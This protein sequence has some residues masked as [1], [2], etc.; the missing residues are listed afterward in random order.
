MSNPSA[1]H[2]TKLLIGCCAAGIVLLHFFLTALALVIEAVSLVAPSHSS[3]V[4]SDNSDE[5]SKPADRAAFEEVFV[6][7]LRGC[8]GGDGERE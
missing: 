3:L 2:L 8:G 7:L 6:C 1:L 4:S 5:L